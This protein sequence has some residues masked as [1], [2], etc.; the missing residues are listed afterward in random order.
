MKRKK[1]LHHIFFITTQMGESLL[2]GLD[3]LYIILELVERILKA[4]VESLMA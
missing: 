4:H 1:I 3:F 2:V